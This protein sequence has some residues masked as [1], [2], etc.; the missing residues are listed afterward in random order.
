MSEL[1][2]EEVF[3]LLQS[4][5]RDFEGRNAELPGLEGSKELLPLPTISFAH[6]QTEGGYAR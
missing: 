5:K 6:V 3:H 2:R 1:T 4:R